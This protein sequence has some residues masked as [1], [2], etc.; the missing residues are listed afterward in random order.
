MMM[1]NNEVTGNKKE[2]TAD[3]IY[4]IL[5]P[6]GIKQKITEV[7]ESNL[8]PNK[9]LQGMAEIDVK[10]MS[11][12]KSFGLGRESAEGIRKSIIAS[13]DGVFALGG[14]LDDI[15]KT[16]QQAS[17]ALGRNVVL[18][19]EE[20]KNLYATSKV[21]GQ[22]VKTVVSSLKDVGISASQASETMF[23]VVKAAN[24][25]GVSAQKTSEMVLKNTSLLN[26]FNFKDGV[27]GMARMAAQAISLR[28]DMTETMKVAQQAFNP[29][30]AIKMAA[31]LQRLG[32]T[33]SELLD[34]LSLM[35]L[36]ENDPAELQNQIAEMSKQFVHL[37]EKGQ[38]EILPGAKR[39]MMEIEKALGLSQGTLSK[40]ALSSAEL[41]EKLK[42]VQFPEFMTEDQKK[43]LANVSEMKDG[44]VMI[45]VNGEKM[46]L[47]KA[48]KGKS[49]EEI[50][51]LIDATKPKSME[52][53]AKSQLDVLQDI[54]I[55]ISLLKGK[56]PTALAGTKAGDAA[57]RGLVKLERESLAALDKAAFG[58]QGTFELSKTLDKNTV[59]LAKEIDKLIKGETT[60]TD[61]LSKI[62]DAIKK[63]FPNFQTD[64]ENVKNKYPILKE[65][66]LSNVDEIAKKIGGAFSDWFTTFSGSDVIVS[67][68]KVIKL[69]PED[70]IMAATGLG[71]LVDKIQSPNQKVIE[72]KKTEAVGDFTSIISDF[73]NK[74]TSRTT[75]PEKV[76]GEMTVNLNLKIDAPPQVDTAQILKILKDQGVTEAIITNIKKVT[77][78]NNLTPLK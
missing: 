41:E 55:G 72:P 52:E 59:E 23:N 33:Q 54:N 39:Q 31:S 51:A 40:M 78:N 35:N 24:Q 34:P 43:M 36:A 65:V 50:D 53:L 17:E 7:L 37:N 63:S 29:E 9:I 48:I 64:M 11:V 71:D 47:S 45:E 61:V 26:Q 15:V 21:T 1:S 13:R 62:P 10:V 68:N 3:E 32:V 60:M 8:M 38:F 73:A 46:E 4:S 70:T 6:E 76:K 20:Q 67:Q 77:S 18:G 16:Q 49:K 30:G 66:T 27:E 22:E 69:L 58:G 57:L 42:R 12:V 28:V 5:T 25:V 19:A 75:E 44:K 74:A 2:P 14:S 56:V